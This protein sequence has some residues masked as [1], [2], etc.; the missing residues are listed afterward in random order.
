MI[1]YDHSEINEEK[2]RTAYRK[3]KRKP[4][5]VRAHTKLNAITAMF[6]G[7]F[8]FF[9]LLS[10]D[11]F[12]PEADK[13]DPIIITIFFVLMLGMMIS[14]FIWIMNLASYKMEPDDEMSKQTRGKAN[15]LAFAV[16]FITVTAL[17]FILEKVR[18][19]AVSALFAQGNFFQLEISGLLTYDSIRH[20][21]F[22]I[23]DRQE[24]S[25]EEEE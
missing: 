16:W 24:M 6:A 21:I 15:G 2:Q 25:D 18:P 19:G 22:L 7:L 12:A 9:M 13:D 3:D 20:F 8:M 23:L 14:G 11:V 4:M 10:F 1:R 5:N 17:F